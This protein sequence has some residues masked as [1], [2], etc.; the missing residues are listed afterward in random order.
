MNIT[1]S[2]YIAPDRLRYIAP[3]GTELQGVTQTVPAVQSVLVDFSCASGWDYGDHT[4]TFWEGASDDTAACHSI[5]LDMNGM[6][7][8]DRFCMLVRDDQPVTP[9]SDAQLRAIHFWHA[10]G[11]IADRLGDIRTRIDGYR[12]HL[13]ASLDQ[14]TVADSREPYGRA[15]A[16]A[17]SLLA[18][19]DSKLRETI[20][21]M[22]RAMAVTQELVTTL[23]GDRCPVC[24]SL[25]DHTG[26]CV[27]PGCPPVAPRSAAAA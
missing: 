8:P 15:N 18:I 23:L 25:L 5:F 10:I 13:V 4:K 9:F 20:A 7:W 19:A 17:D 1:Q 12:D 11:T 2:E 6:D 26:E 27:A 21:P 24:R 16:L 22:T 3:D 14:L